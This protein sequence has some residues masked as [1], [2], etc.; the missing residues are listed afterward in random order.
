VSFMRALLVPSLDWLQP[1]GR[2][3]LRSL[4]VALLAQRTF[5][6]RRSGCGGNKISKEQRY[7]A[8]AECRRL[9]PAPPVAALGGERVTSDTY[10]RFLAVCQW[11]PV[12]AAKLLEKDLVWRRKYRPRSLKPSDMPNGCSQ[13]GWQVLV[14]PVGGG[15]SADEGDT[16]VEG[17]G[18]SSGSG[19]TRVRFWRR[20]AM[21]TGQPQLHPPHTRPALQQWRYT[22]SG[23]PITLFEASSWHPE[24]V[25]HDERVRHTA[26]HMEHYIRRMP[27]RG[28]GY[29]ARRVQR[30]CIVLDMTGFRPTTLPQV[31]ECIDVLRNHYPG[32]LGVAAFINVPPYF[33]PVW[34]M[35]S[36]LLDEEILSKTF[37]L[38]AAVDNAEKA[39]KWIDEK[40]Q[41]PDP[42]TLP[43]HLNLRG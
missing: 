37:F 4:V 14:T 8:L 7:H 29:G 34:R 3:P 10:Y 22:R 24:R 9:V 11:D 20:L 41:L 19:R 40:K 31:K 18:S 17:S 36:P 26:Y 25:P 23:M 42:T 21:T 13:R 30:V 5:L 1:L 32:R 33:H 6:A 28:H 35:I 27:H 38:P 16:Y 12:K 15:W 43:Q 2:H 39:I